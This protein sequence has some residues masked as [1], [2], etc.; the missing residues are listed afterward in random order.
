MSDD[1]VLYERR[2]AAAW[3]TLNRPEA[4]NALTIPLTRCL[5]ECLT[6]AEADPEARVVVITGAGRAFCAGADLKS[7]RA[8]LADD[9][10][11][12][13]REF[14]QPLLAVLNR[15][16]ASALPVIA[17]VNGIAAAGGLETILACDLVVAA[18]SARIGDA[19]AN[20]GLI[21]GGAGSVR[22]PR[23]IGPTR[24]KALLFTGRF[25][26]PAELAEMGLVNEVVA[27][28]ALIPTVEALV[29]EIAGKSP[30]SI[31]AMKRLVR[32]GMEQSLDT[33]INLEYTMLMTHM[34]SA[35]VAEGLDAFE[36]KRRPQFKGR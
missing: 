19:H 25:A 31:S 34:R 32:D 6:Q 8:L 20:Y 17:A 1:P 26:A 5:D 27:D 18:E 7:I 35:D 23:K 13:G 11:R 9:V 22:L 2:G 4:L 24:A 14:V 29:E 10:E 21:P 12:F 15:L 16:E 30:L 28:E 36:N 33:A 3:L